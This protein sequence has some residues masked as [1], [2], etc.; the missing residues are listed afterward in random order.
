MQTKTILIVVFA[1]LSVTLVGALAYQRTNQ[2]ETALV[3]V[4][5]DQNQQT[6]DETVGWNTYTNEQYGFEMKYSIDWLYKDYY[7]SANDPILSEVFFSNSYEQLSEKYELNTISVV[8]RP[9]EI[10]VDDM[11]FHELTSPISIVFVDGIES[12]K[13]S[14]TKLWDMEGFVSVVEVVIPK[15]NKFY[16]VSAWGTDNLTTFDQMLSTFKFIK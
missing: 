8:A 2:P 14:G 7:N 9:Y 10:K 13:V 4:V 15:N 12:T 6:Q 5:I 11:G 3:P 1:V 16:T